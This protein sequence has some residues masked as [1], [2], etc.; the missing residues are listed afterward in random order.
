M[1]SVNLWGAIHCIH[2]F[3]PL[4]VGNESGGHVVNVA[5]VAAVT[6][7]PGIAPY[8]VSKYGLLALSE[9]LHADLQASGEQRGG[10]RRDAR[11]RRDV[12]RVPEWRARSRSRATRWLRPKQGC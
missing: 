4:M 7:V 11:A 5:S 9:T 1:L 8:N 10:H 12:A 3:V 6:P 2:A